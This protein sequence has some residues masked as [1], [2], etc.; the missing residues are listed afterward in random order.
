MRRKVERGKKM[1][2]FAA[3]ASIILYIITITGILFYHI[4]FPYQLFCS[5]ILSLSSWL[6]MV[7]MVRNFCPPL[8]L[9]CMDWAFFILSCS[10]T[11]CK[12]RWWENY[13]HHRLFY[14]YGSM[15]TK[16]S[17]KTSRTSW[18]ATKAC[19][20]AACTMRFKRTTSWL[21]MTM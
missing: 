1:K 6:S 10:S 18:I 5:F 12:K 13:S 11:A 15:A 17:P 7:W 4:T 14:L 8:P 16:P 19:S 21:L 20:S 9:A 2:H 3:I